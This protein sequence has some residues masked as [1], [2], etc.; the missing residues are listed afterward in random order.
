[1]SRKFQPV[2]NIIEVIITSLLGTESITAILVFKLIRKA[3][4][5]SSWLSKPS[6]IA[7]LSW[8]SIKQFIILYART[9]FKLNI[10]HVLRNAETG[11]F[12]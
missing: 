7:C 9:K 11:S 4:I 1:M 2:Y 6:G 10:L 8:N 3:S 12:L 5:V